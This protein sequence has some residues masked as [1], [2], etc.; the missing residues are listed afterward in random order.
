V[1]KTSTRSS[2]ALERRKQLRQ[3]RRQERW[4]QIWRIAV[5]S[6]SAGAMGWLLLQQGWV[7]RSPNQIE[8]IGS[9]QVNRERVIQ[10]GKLNLPLQLL[11][12]RPQLL[13]NQLSAGLPVEYVQVSRLML[14]PRLQIKLVDREAVA[15]AQRR[16]RSGFE[17]GFVDRLGNWMTRRQ[18]QGGSNAAAPTVMVVGWQEALKAPLAQ[19]LAQRNHLGSALQQVRFDPNGS[20]WLRTAA[21]GDIHLGPP[22]GRLA[23]RLDVLRHLSKELPAQI[24]SLKVQ[25]IDLSDPDQPELGLPAKPVAKAATAA[26]PAA[27]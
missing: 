4:K 22:D 26:A 15:Q 17:M 25:S 5:L 6:G 14:P 13:A 9:R 1:T 3:E 24:R 23:E 27:D 12:L 18:Q 8:V 7:V 2:L 19:V 16:T 11:T 20:L 10:E 21:L